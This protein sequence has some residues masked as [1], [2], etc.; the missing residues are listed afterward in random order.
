MQQAAYDDGGY[1]AAR[2]VAGALAAGGLLLH[3]L[4]SRAWVADESAGG[5]RV[6]SCGVAA[7]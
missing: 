6:D 4:C 5:L 2:P 1:I 7:A 3:Y